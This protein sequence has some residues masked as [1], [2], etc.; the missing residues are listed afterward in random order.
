MNAKT[1]AP[2]AKRSGDL[3]DQLVKAVKARSCRDSLD[4]QCRALMAQRMLLEWMDRTPA[5]RKREVNRLRRE[6]HRVGAAWYKA[7]TK[8]ERAAK[9]A[10]GA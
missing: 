9:S 1:K 6:Y 5:D 10:A 8:C 4:A 7:H 2:G 3:M